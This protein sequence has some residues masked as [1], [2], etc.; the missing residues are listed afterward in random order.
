MGKL[1]A[2]WLR[3]DTQLTQSCDLCCANEDGDLDFVLVGT[4]LVPRPSL[5]PVFVVLAYCKQS[6]TGVGEGLGT[7]LVD[8]TFSGTFGNHSIADNST[9]ARVYTHGES[10]VM[11]GSPCSYTFVSCQSVLLQ[12]ASILSGPYLYYDRTIRRTLIASQQLC[13]TRASVEQY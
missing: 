6:K 2:I 4:S 7:R 13:M 5:A 11:V 3:M 10:N 9:H 8:K 1:K 12:E